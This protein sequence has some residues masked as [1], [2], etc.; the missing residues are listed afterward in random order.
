MDCLL[1]CPSCG[2]NQESAI[3]IGRLAK[4]RNLEVAKLRKKNRELAKAL[5]R[6][7]AKDSQCGSC[8][9]AKQ[10]VEFD[11]DTDK[12][13]SLMEES[14]LSLDSYKSEADQTKAEE[15]GDGACPTVDNKSN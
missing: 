6:Q 8:K 1:F 2:I 14:V 15:I 7:N 11:D 4:D 10:E 13:L 9:K 3:A 12:D 5:N